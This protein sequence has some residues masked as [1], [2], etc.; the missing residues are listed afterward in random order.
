MKKFILAAFTL[1]IFQPQLVKAEGVYLILK[2]IGYNSNGL[3]VIPIPMSSM[4]SCETAGLKLISSDRFHKK[5]LGHN[6]YSRMHYLYE[7]VENK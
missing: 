6:Y 3:S 5:R 2:S 4:E 7:C 1:F